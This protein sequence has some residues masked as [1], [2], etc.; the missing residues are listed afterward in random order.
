MSKGDCSQGMHCGR[1]FKS[2][3]LINQDLANKLWRVHEGNQ[4]G[5]KMK[6]TTIPEVL[7]D[8]R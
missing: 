5:P 4:S 1:L 6:R 3:V 2:R 7:A 8:L